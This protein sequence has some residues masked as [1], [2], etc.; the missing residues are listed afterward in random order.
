MVQLRQTLRRLLAT[1]LQTSVVLASIA[2]GL[3]AP[4]ALYT[5]AASLFTAPPFRAPG[6]LA[7]IY[8]WQLLDGYGW[9]S[10]AQYRRVQ[11]VR[12]FSSVAAVREHTGIV[13]RDGVREERSL[14][15]VS[16]KLFDTLGIDVA[17]GRLPH[18][19]GPTPEVAISYAFWVAAYQQQPD[20][21]G[22]T[23]EI[24]GHRHRVTGVLELGL[25]GLHANRSVDIWRPWSRLPAPDPN[26]RDLW[27]VARLRPGAD[28]ISA[29]EDLDR[30]SGDSSHNDADRLGVFAYG[31]YAPASVERTRTIAMTLLAATT[32]LF[33][34]ACANVSYVFLARTCDRS[35][36]FSILLALGATRRQVLTHAVGEAVFVTCAGGPMAA[37]LAYWIAAGLPALF[38]EQQARLLR[39]S[40]HPATVLGACVLGLVVLLFS[41]LVPVALASRSE[42]G[43]ILQSPESR[44]G[45][46]P[47]G[48][49]VRRMLVIFQMAVSLA[50]LSGLNGLVSAFH[51]ALDTN[52][53]VDAAQVLLAPLRASGGYARPDLGIAYFRNVVDAVRSVAGV[54]GA[55]LT[56]VAPGMRPARRTFLVGGAA[57]PERKPE[58]LAT[59]LVSPD[60]FRAVGI[61]TEAGSTFAGSEADA[62][63]AVVDV[64]L[65]RQYFGGDAL[66][67]MLVDSDG[68]AHRII[69]IVGSSAPGSVRQA[70]DPTVYLPMSRSYA[71]EMMLVVS[72][73]RGATQVGGRIDRA[74]RRVTGGGPMAEVAGLDAFVRVRSPFNSVTMVIMALCAAAA[75]GLVSTGVYDLSRY[76]IAARRREI[77]L[78]MALG[79]TRARI[80]RIVF[81]ELM[82]VLAVGL[83][84]GW[85]G[86][87]GVS[88]FLRQ[89]FELPVS[90]DPAGLLRMAAL[91]LGI[92]AVAVVPAARQA[93]AIAPARALGS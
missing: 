60:Y 57:A 25:D 79:A 40:P 61:A 29:R 78:R 19:A 50:M 26:R 58:L 83:P 73:G 85:A 48:R 81:R 93:I 1:P 63:T 74:I 77:A 71:P 4:V 20:V 42:A 90:L 34:V 52:H 45:G 31:K 30:R 91:L 38:Y 35:G 6:R 67:R 87:L 47:T 64:T 55:G 46:A 53:D 68:V 72:V 80:G 51:A 43:R 10:N 82:L 86:A 76:L 14:A 39:W 2:I 59:S 44:T 5:F 11:A 36:E 33:L 37:L 13:V 17:A 88:D 70:P 22:S 18:A 69:G 92:A 27:V 7:E 16:D 23:I 24:D 54:T 15:E 62:G 12:E 75:I 28:I 8:S 9:C 32:L 65:S 3:G 41:S 49:G 56:S 84:V 89:R 21:L 66:G